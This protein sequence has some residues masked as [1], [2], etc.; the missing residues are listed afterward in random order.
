MSEFLSLLCRAVEATSQNNA[1]ALLLSGGLDST[2]VGIALQK[3]GKI[4]R[5]YTY[6]LQGYPSRDL[7]KAIAIANNFGWPLSIIEVPIA[8]VAHDF[9]RLAIAQRCRKKT[10]FEV[11]FP[12]LYV[13]PQINETE[14][15]TGWNAD[16]HYGNTKNFILSVRGMSRAERKQAFDAERR[17]H[18]EQKFANVET[19]ETWCYARRLAAQQGKRLLDPYL[20]R[21]VRLSPVRSRAAVA[22]QQTAYPASVGRRTSRP[23]EREPGRRHSTPDWRGRRCAIRHTAAKPRD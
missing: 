11:L 5:A 16:N 17:A 13:F 2:S 3:T 19:G 1:V 21:A 4:I 10:H 6:R 20:D 12:L 23:A 9:M 14:I 18:F 22:A 15:W 8:D 7:K